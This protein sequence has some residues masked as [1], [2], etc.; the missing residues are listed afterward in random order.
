MHMLRAVPARM[1]ALARREPRLGRHD[2]LVAE[3]T[4]G[5]EAAQ[6]L[7]AP[8]ARIDV[9][10]VDEVAPGIHIRVEHRPR[11]VLSRAPASGAERHGAKGKGTTIRPGRPSER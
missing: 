9:G 8:P 7:L 5:D 11:A 1:N 2:H 10:G 4:L 6:Q 3:T